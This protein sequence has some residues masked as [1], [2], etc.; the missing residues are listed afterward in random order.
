MRIEYFDGIPIVI[1]NE[2]T[3]GVD[4]YISYH[5][6]SADYGSDTTAFVT[7]TFRG[8]TNEKG[9]KIAPSSS[10]YI[11]N[12]DHRAG[13]AACEDTPTKVKYLMDNEHLKNHISDDFSILYYFLVLEGYIQHDT[14]RPTQNE[15]CHG[16]DSARVMKFPNQFTSQVEYPHYVSYATYNQHYHAWSGTTALVITEGPAKGFY[17]ISGDYFK[18]L[19]EPDTLQGKIDL[20]LLW[21]KNEKSRPNST[22]GWHIDHSDSFEKLR[23]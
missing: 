23:I 22:G 17:I 14:S 7:Q 2:V 3:E 15:L 13:L 11:L 18:F 20:L 21:E 9:Q 12:G 8:K 1:R 5:P 19:A 4:H 6:W 16:L 10:F